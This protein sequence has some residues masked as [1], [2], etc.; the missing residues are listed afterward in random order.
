MRLAPLLLLLA[1][2]CGG[3][4]RP[5]ASELPLDA[6]S[7]GDFDA[8]EARLRGSSD[9]ESRYLL[10]KILLMR[11]KPAEAAAILREISPK[12]VRS[13]DE[14]FFAER[15]AAD[16]ALAS[17]RQDDYLQASQTFARLQDPARARKYE[18]LGRAVGHRT[19]PGWDESVLELVSMDP[20]PT[21]AGSV[22]GRRGVFVIDTG[23]GETLLDRDF[24]RRAGVTAVA[25]PGA[26]STEAVA[27]ELSFG[28]LAVRGV[29]VTLGSR[30]SRAAARADGALG[31]AF[32]LHFEVELDLRRGRL[33][34]RRPGA[35]LTSTASARG[36]PAYVAG[37]AQLLVAGRVNGS[38]TLVGIGTAL[39][40]VTAAPSEPFFAARGAALKDVALANLRLAG[41]PATPDA[42]PVGLDGSY[43]FSV[44]VVL[45]PQALRG[46]VLALDPRAMKLTID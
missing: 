36:V 21:V 11:H 42:F 29:P 31:L 9:L 6:F 34:L 32:L 28:R 12:Q 24:A 10:A 38:P 22:N 26:T 18:I 19:N 2:G 33:T 15:I 40:G 4:A 25:V 44:P 5:P 14:A 3:G 41:P 1:V 27:D 46:R 13:V 23:L 45:G 39:A 37:D 43:G 7:R 16:L 20:V 17:L 30:E 8:A 35:G